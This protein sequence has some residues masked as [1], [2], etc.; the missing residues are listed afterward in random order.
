MSHNNTI[1]IL[2]NRLRKIGIDIKRRWSIIIFFSM[3][4][5]TGTAVRLY[6]LTDQTIGITEI[7][8][9]GL[10]L[11]IGLSIPAPRH[12]IRDII[13]GVVWE[14]EPNPPGYY[15]MMLVWDKVFGTGI[16]SLRFPTV[17][18]GIC[19]IPLIFL[20]AK[21]EESIWVALLAAG[22]L[23]LNGH[24]IYWSMIAKMYIFGI[25]LGLLST[26]MLLYYTRSFSQRR[27]FLYLYILQ[28]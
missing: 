26:L 16:L 8:K 19:C 10:N 22:M 14:E 5:I 25:F 20:L 23:A 15:F 1:R 27:I 11:P 7:N 2:N 17:I 4:L 18:F 9:P 24:Q 28:L 12:T 3:I 13:A 21:K 6:H